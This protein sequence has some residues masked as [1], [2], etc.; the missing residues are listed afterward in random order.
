VYVARRTLQGTG[1]RR[2]RREMGE[3]IQTLKCFV[4]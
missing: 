4:R 1:I 3:R 2:Q